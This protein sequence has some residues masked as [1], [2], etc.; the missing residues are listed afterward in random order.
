MYHLGVQVVVEC[1]ELR[2]LV[3]PAVLLAIDRAERALAESSP[4]LILEDGNGAS[5]STERALVFISTAAASNRPL[6]HASVPPPCLSRV[7]DRAEAFGPLSF[8]GDLGVTLGMGVAFWLLL[9]R[10]LNQICGKT[11]QPERK[12]G[13]ARARFKSRSKLRRCC[14]IALKWQ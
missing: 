12:S 4:L 10:D 13:A 14:C 2:A 6:P 5:A 11:Q 1:T 9:C 7:L 8:C 3:D